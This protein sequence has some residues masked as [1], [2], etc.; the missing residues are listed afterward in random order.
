MDTA[1]HMT[2]AL[3]AIFLTAH[4]LSA[5]GQERSPAQSADAF[6]GTWVLNLAKSVYE[7]QPAPK[8]VIRTFDYERDGLILVTAHTTSTAGSM[9]FVHYLFTL[10]GKEYEEK[11][12]AASGGSAN[13]T[14]T[15]VS[16]TKAGDRA[17]N[18]VFKSG[19]RVTI[20]HEWSVSDDG[21]TLTA[22]RTAANAQGQRTYSV[23]VYDK[24]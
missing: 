12:R 16:A 10:D 24:H 17:I 2:Q 18:L 19:G 23:Q 6:V 14:P 3:V 13:R 15:F 20:T 5:Q 11:T 7:N 1:R 8:S 4:I 21:K 22:K 9:S